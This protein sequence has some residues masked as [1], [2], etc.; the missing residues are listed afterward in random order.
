MAQNLKQSPGN[1][2]GSGV[3]ASVPANPSGPSGPSDSLNSSG[4]PSLPRRLRASLMSAARTSLFAAS[5]LVDRMNFARHMGF[6][7]Y[8]G[9]RNLFTALGYEDNLTISHYRDMYRRGGIAKTIIDIRPN[10]MWSGGVSISESADPNE[11]T[12]FD[13]DIQSLFDRLNVVSRLLKTDKLAGLGHYAAM[14]IGVKD[15]PG[16]DLS[17]EMPQLNGPDSV[18]Y[19][20]SYAEDC[21]KIIELD[22]DVFSERFGQ[23]LFYQL[24]SQSP[25][26]TPNGIKIVTKANSTLSKVHWSRVIHIAHDCLESDY[27]GSPDLEV[28]WNLLTDLLK[29]VGGGAEAAWRKMDQGLHANLDP[30]YEFDDDDIEK[31]EERLEEYRHQLRRDLLTKGIDITPLSS[32]V[33]KFGTNIDPLI[34]LICATIRISKR[35]FEGSERGELASSQDQDNLASTISTRRQNEGEPTVRQFVDRL[36]RYQG[37]AKPSSGQYVIDWYEE[38]ELDE[39]EK[40]KLALTLAQANQAQSLAGG[41]P[42]N[43]GDEIRDKVWGD[44]PIE[45]PGVLEEDEEEEDKTEIQRTTPED[46]IQEEAVV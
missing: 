31:F 2:N 1:G 27:I 21:A 45:M 6:D 29:V 19:L 8:G 37:V 42:I 36:I 38:E 46:S 3:D 13:K 23:P 25:Q 12:Q 16:A 4:S 33:D 30:D 26:S 35:I 7:S 40:A 10:E 24:S 28:V 15:R 39:L 41:T 20:Q 5:T 17:S 43:T 22:E 18:I 32:S 34:Q 11:E 44:E 14:L 9:V